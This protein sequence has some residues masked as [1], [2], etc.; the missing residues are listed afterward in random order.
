MAL[1]TNEITTNRPLEGRV[2]LVTGASRGIGQAIARTLGRMGAML[3]LCARD[4]QKLQS[5][6]HDLEA[7]GARVLALPADV[8]SPM[9]SHR[10]C[11]PRSVLLVLSRFS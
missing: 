10:L 2:A 1:G 6:C 4:T 11:K 3:S 7:E 9:K 8:S 5:A